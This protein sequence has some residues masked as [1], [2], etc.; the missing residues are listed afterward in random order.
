MLAFKAEAKEWVNKSLTT[1]SIGDGQ[2][3]GLSAAR[4]QGGS[5]PDSRSSLENPNI[6]V[7]EVNSYFIYRGVWCPWGCIASLVIVLSIVGM[8]QMAYGQYS[9][10]CGDRLP[11]SPLLPSGEAALKVTP[12]ICVSERYDSNIFY[13]QATPGLTRNDFVTNVSPRLLVNHNSS[14][15]SGV[16]DAAGFS[17]TYANNPDLNYFGTNDRLFLNLDN[18]I[19]RLLPNASMRITDVVR[20]TP[21][22]PGYPSLATGTSPGD[23]ANIP[24]AFAQGY[25]LQR[26]NNVTNT[27]TVLVSYATTAATS[28]EASYTHALVRFG[29]SP[30]IPQQAQVTNLFDIT[31]QTGTVGGIIRVSGLDM[32][33]PKF[34][35]TQ[36]DASPV[37]GG[38]A[39]NTNVDTASLTWTRT[40]TPNLTAELGG[41][42]VVMDPGITTYVANAALIM[43]SQNNS[44]TISY[45]RSAYPRI[46]S[47]STA[48]AT[49]GGDAMIVDMFSLSA[50]Q[51][52]SQQWQ[53][54]EGANYSQGSSTNLNYESIS[55]SVSSYYW[56]TRIWSLA[57]SYDYMSYNTAFTTTGTAWARNAVTFSLRATWE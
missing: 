36:F 33:N 2:A 19:K 57:L 15:A 31:S 49:G 7:K 46:Q 29:S 56:M 35:H 3:S 34:S 54:T 17:E 23:P 6:S 52:L 9:Q 11:P 10:S 28:L 30:G 48:G 16:L 25:L 55:A 24:N 27:G 50:I 47:T 5:R 38:T 44:A 20:Y 43:R 18:S 22:P 12:S 42:G 37:S 45:A 39:F 21:A 4:W 13:R 1:P 51:N 26:T 53:L 41:G 40:L 8:E 14:Y 32:L